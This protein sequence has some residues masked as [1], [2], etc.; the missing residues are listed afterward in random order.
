[1][2]FHHVRSIISQ[3]WINLRH[4]PSSFNASDPL[5]KHWGYQS[6]VWKTILQPLLHHQGDTRSLVNDDTYL[7][8]GSATIDEIIS[9]LCRQWGV[10]N[11]AEGE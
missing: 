8:D 11:I 4:I 9:A 7:V 5:T 1:M 2:S 3:G 10:S 6:A